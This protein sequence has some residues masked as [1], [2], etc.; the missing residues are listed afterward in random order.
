LKH[1]FNLVIILLVL[2]MLGAAKVLLRTNPVLALCVLA[3][4]G[5]L[6]YICWHFYPKIV[7]KRE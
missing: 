7:T 6:L 5:V 2:L 3:G 1:F 4:S